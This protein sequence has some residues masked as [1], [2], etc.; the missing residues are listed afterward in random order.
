MREEMGCYRNDPVVKF[1]FV[2]PLRALDYMKVMADEE[3]KFVSQTVRDLLIEAIEARLAKKA[4]VPG[5]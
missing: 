5:A 1:N 4:A 2:L 3:H